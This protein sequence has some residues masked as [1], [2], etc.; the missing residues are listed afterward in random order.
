MDL[1]RSFEGEFDM[2]QPLSTPAN[3]LFLNVDCSA[4]LE[5]YRLIKQIAYPAQVLA[6][7]KSNAY[8]LSL[9][10]IS[11]ILAENGLKWIGCASLSE[12]LDIKKVCG[13]FVEILLMHPP[14]AEEIPILIQENFI[15]S[16]T[17]FDLALKLSDEAVRQNRKIR[18]HL[19]INVGINRLGIDPEEIKEKSEL[20]FS[21]PGLDIV[22][23]SSHFS[24]ADGPDPLL[25]R[26]EF[27]KFDTI[28][29]FL[30]EKG[31]IF[32]VKHIS[33]SAGLLNFPEY[34]MD[35]VRAGIL[36]YGIS[37]G[38]QKHVPETFKPVVSLS[39]RIAHLFTIKKGEGVSYHHTWVSPE[40]GA[41]ATL[42]VGYADGI[43][44][45]LSNKG[46]VLIHGERFPIVGQICMDLMVVSLGN[47]PANIGEE[48]VLLGRQGKDEIGVLDWA[49]WGNMNPHEILTGLGRALPKL[50]L[51]EKEVNYGKTMRCVRKRSSYRV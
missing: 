14:Y 31:H 10:K 15:Q 48:V 25:P 18:V 13:K 47:K 20:I 29:K 5:N 30:A 11:K 40:K 34:R 37:P 44:G 24:S 33:N 21:M 23:I 42:P 17:S 38:F 26:E 16:L 41:L 4:L 43:P 49:K 6:V 28:V 46:E 36:L 7:L 50:Y 1:T 3:K 9:S 12:A 27:K 32:P 22:G 35:M 39:T 8:G 51:H 45:A 2:I 19:D